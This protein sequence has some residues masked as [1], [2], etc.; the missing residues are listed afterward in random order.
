[1]KVGTA[2]KRT[3]VKLRQPSQQEATKKVKSP[4][5]TSKNIESDYWAGSGKSSPAPFRLSWDSTV[6]DGEISNICRG[7]A[8]IGSGWRA[9]MSGCHSSVDLDPGRI[10]LWFPPSTTGIRYHAIEFG[11]HQ[12]SQGG[13]IRL[14]VTALAQ[15]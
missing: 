3:K 13:V 6:C 10:T 11:R 9:T 14:F 7:R 2:L 1:M 8:N 4:Q 12:K 5:F 15:H